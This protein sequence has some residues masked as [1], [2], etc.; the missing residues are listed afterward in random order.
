MS[1]SRQLPIVTSGQ[2]GEPP[3]FNK[4][5]IVGLGLI[6]G[7][8]AIASRQIWPTGLIIAVDQKEVLE[9]AMVRHAIDIAADDLVV[10]AEADLIILAA[11]VLQN[12]DLL[13]SLETHVKGSAVVTDVGST[14]REIIEA[15][16]GISPKFTFVGGHPM[17]GATQG[18][19]SNARKD[20][21]SGRPWILTPHDDRSGD[22][23]EKLFQLTKSFG[24]LP[25]IMNGAT[26]DTMVAS[27]SHLPQLT[28]SVLMAVIGKTVGSEGLALAGRGLIDTTRLASSPPDI[29]KDVCATNGDEIRVALDLLV[30][31]LNLLKTDLENGDV[32]DEV[33]KEASQW[34]QELKKKTN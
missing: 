19:F 27:L 26:H 11:P 31:K 17:A 1:A 6:G 13:K 10:L 34:R 25:Q 30:E 2:S 16:R 9:L 28:A 32:L 7:S 15:A 23:V 14:K 21:F 8:I 24:A 5:G 3:I 18:G 22:A 20:L 29:W 33:F 4:I 12:I